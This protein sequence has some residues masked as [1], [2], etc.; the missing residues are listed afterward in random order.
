MDDLAFAI[1]HTAL[2][3]LRRLEASNSLTP[4]FDA[5]RTDPSSSTTDLYIAKWENVGDLIG[6]D[7]VALARML[8]PK[9]RDYLIALR[10]FNKVMHSVPSGSANNT[11]ASAAVQEMANMVIK[12]ETV[13]SFIYLADR[14]ALETDLGQRLFTLI[15]I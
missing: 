15:A 13:A 5:S 2:G 9:I 1:R 3:V 7:K 8:A 11:I 12:L 14:P 4:S 6:K 10:M